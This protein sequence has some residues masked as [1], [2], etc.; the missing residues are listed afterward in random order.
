MKTS[1]GGTF[2]DNMVGATAFME[3]YELV[4]AAPGAPAA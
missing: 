1:P 2:D 4:C 3:T